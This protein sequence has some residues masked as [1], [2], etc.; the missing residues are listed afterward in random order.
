MIDVS[1]VDVETRKISTAAAGFV[2]VGLGWSAPDA[3]E[4]EAES[5][6]VA[7]ESDG[8]AAER[9]IA[10]LVVLVYTSSSL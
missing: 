3:K 6:G 2:T 10:E 4:Q 9:A 7:A 1:V 8:V 5:D